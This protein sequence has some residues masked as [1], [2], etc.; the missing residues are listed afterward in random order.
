MWSW[1]WTWSLLS[2]CALAGWTGNCSVILQT[3]VETNFWWEV[4]WV[5]NIHWIYFG[6]RF[7]EWQ[8]FIGSIF[9]WKF[10]E[11]QTLIGSIF[12]WDVFLVTLLE[13]FLSTFSSFIELDWLFVRNASPCLWPTM[14]SNFV[15]VIICCWFPWKFS[16]F[17]Q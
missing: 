3:F 13:Y 14:M 16:L 8:T 2:T 12:W 5:T 10:F 7:F 9:G 15:H 17:C 11:W 1:Q 6:G 4:F